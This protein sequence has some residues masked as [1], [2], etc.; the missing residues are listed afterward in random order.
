MAKYNLKDIKGKDLPED[1]N[2][3]ILEQAK[4]RFKD[5]ELYKVLEDAKQKKLFGKCT[6]YGLTDDMGFVAL[7][8]FNFT[9]GICP[10]MKFFKVYGLPL[11]IKGY[12]TLFQLS[13]H[14]DKVK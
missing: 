7:A 8:E 3:S 2:D 1:V 10:N 5:E 9:A 4:K 11:K 13:I 14:N 12:R 6:F